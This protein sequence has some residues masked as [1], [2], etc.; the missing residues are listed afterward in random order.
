MATGNSAKIV[1]APGRLVVNPT[2]NLAT[3]SFPNG[4]WAV[5]HV[6]Q[7]RVQ[8][9][10]TTLRV[11]SEALGEYTDLIEGNRRWVFSCFLRGWDDDAIERLLSD[12]Y[13][14]GP[15]TQ[16]SSFAVPGNHEVGTSA[17]G[18]A[19][20]LLYVPDA[21]ERVPAVLIYRAIPEMA[22]GAEMLFQRNA[23]LGIPLAFECLR[24]D[25]GRIL[26]VGLIHDL[27]I[28]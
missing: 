11:F 15:A 28:D 6:S 1:R 22:D 26:H 4:G 21:P 19:V 23:E 18:R 27:P 12:G 9:L 25:D 16:H 3:G 24:D 8:P 7:C 13:E 5:G 14:R 10:G 17:L 20:R 2:T